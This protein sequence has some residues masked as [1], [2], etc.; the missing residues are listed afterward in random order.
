MARVKAAAVEPL[1]RSLVR[2]IV[3]VILGIH[4]PDGR[5][6]GQRRAQHPA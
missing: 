4:D 1:P 5:D 6:D 2:V 3:V